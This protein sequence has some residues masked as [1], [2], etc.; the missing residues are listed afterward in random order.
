MGLFSNK[1]PVFLKESSSLNEQLEKLDDLKK[2]APFSMQNELDQAINEVKSGIQGEKNIAFELKNSHMP[3]Y[4]LH[5]IYLKSSTGLTAQIDY[6]VVTSGKTFFIECKNLYGKITVDSKGNFTRTVQYGRTKKTEGIY[7]PITQNQRHL[8]VYRQIL[9][10]NNNWIRRKAIS[11][12]GLYAYHQGIV[13]LANP[14]T[15]LNDKYAKKE[16]K[17]QIIRADGLIAYIKNANKKFGILDSMTDKEMEE[18]AERLLFYNQENPTDYTEKYE[19]ELSEKQQFEDN[20]KE[21]PTICPR[22]G[23]KLI[24]RHGKYGKFMGCSNYP[25]CRYTRNIEE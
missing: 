9:M 20:A 10:D 23:G 15:V 5:D 18:K 8:E 7:S 12:N 1:E 2:R 6:I 14:T 17:D 16:I 24:L 25:K 21:D 3:M 13:V 11:G 22:C 4:V 19:K